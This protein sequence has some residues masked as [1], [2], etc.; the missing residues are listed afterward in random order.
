MW[1]MATGDYPFGAFV[2]VTLQVAGPVAVISV[3]P[4]YQPI[5]S[6]KE[7]ASRQN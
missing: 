4:H 1:V 5:A 6:L 7:L 2:E 3:P